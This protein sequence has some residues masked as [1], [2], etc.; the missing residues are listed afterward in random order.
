[1]RRRLLLRGAGVVLALV[2]VGA[3]WVAVT[4]RPFPPDKTP[5]GTYAR[6]ALAMAERR[7]RD[8]FPFLERDA[9]WATYTIRDLRREACSRVRASYPPDAG[10]PL[11]DAWH[12]QGDADDPA[13]VFTLMATR[14]G[15]I[16]RLERDLSGVDH[17]EVQGAR[18]TV[19]TSRGTRY[20]FRMR[21]NGAWGLTLFTADLTA[22]AERAARDL[23]VVKRAAQDYESS[24]ARSR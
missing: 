1:M 17:V 22:E 20:S 14:R 9:E 4:F 23:D 7:T 19:V 21:D 18:A 15:W 12:E 2:V 8:L 16:A 10:A 11:L 13:D 6:I 5:E 3:A 24:G